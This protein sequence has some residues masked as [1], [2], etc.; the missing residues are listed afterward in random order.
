M[1]RSNKLVTATAFKKVPALYSQDGKGEEARAHVKFFSNFSDHRHYVLEY[2]PLDGI[3]FCLTTNGDVCE[4]G[5]IS[6]PE[7]QEMNDNF[8]KYGYPCPVWQRELHGGPSAGYRIG[9]VQAE[10]DK[11]M[12]VAV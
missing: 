10:H 2:N 7:L 1:A 9:D 5:Y 6:I 3:A 12:G 11:S 8:R 4:Y